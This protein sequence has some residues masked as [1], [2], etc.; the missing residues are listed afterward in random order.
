VKRPRRHVTRRDV[1]RLRGQ[2]TDPR[3][4][5][6]TPA[7]TALLRREDVGF[8]DIIRASRTAMG[9]YFEVRLPACAPGAAGLAT[10]ALDVI[11]E[12][13][14]QLTIY[15]DDSEVSR[16]NA[17]AHNGPVEVEPRLF[18]LLVTAVTIGSAT[19]GSYD[20]TS[21]A[22]SLAWGF[23]KGPKR[24]PEPEDL[25]DARARTGQDHITL[26]R[27]RTTVA[28][29]RPGIVINLGSI[30]KG[31]AID[32]AVDLI[33][34]YWW[35]TPA[36]VHGGRSSLYALGSPPGT[37]GGR[38]QVA[39]RNPFVPEKTLGVLHLRNRGLGTSGA[40][41]QQFEVEG[42]VYGHI[43][44]PRSGEPALG[45]ASVTVLAPTAAEADALSTAF[46]LLG[47]DATAAYVEKHAGV[48]ALLVTEGP[49]PAAPKV[50]GFGVEDAF[51]PSG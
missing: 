7:E 31:Y 8:A 36:L 23:V 11:E 26:D 16:L 4:G 13:E 22:L 45:P 40:A 30:G 27:E 34:A 21:G 10:R 42:R 18:R 41:Y 17:T 20:V 38:W 19:G 35:P 28:F 50:L 44:D 49:S 3:W 48:A 9:S 46:Y 12:L 5:A 15:R 39:V 47:P 32:R 33:R 51:E 2:G 43:I 29:D 14:S 37:V 25:A 6:E 1:L 24:V